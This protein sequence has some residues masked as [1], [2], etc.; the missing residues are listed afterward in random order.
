MAP[1]RSTTLRPGPVRCCAPVTVTGWLCRRAGLAAGSRA[2]LSRD[3]AGGLATTNRLE[4]LPRQ[5]C[6]PRGLRRV[7]RRRRPRRARRRVSP[8][9]TRGHVRRRGQGMVRGGIRADRPCWRAVVRGGPVRR[10]GGHAA[11]GT[12]PPRRRPPPPGS[13]ASGGVPMSLPG[14]AVV[15]PIARR[16]PGGVLSEA[17]GPITSF[18]AAATGRART[19]GTD[20]DPGSARQQPKSWKPAAYGRV[21]EEPGAATVEPRHT[22][23]PHLHP[24][25]AGRWGPSWGASPQAGSGGGVAV[26][27]T[28]T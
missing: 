2:R 26:P 22:R 6:R 14:A 8:R 13:G 7:R 3:G 9:A 19:Q 18:P 12:D 15:H 5:R 27:S 20:A 4:W 1:P 23:R 28:T 21:A 17:A 25:R 10:R 24:R 16:V 11:R